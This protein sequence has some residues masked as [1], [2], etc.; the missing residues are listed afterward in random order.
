MFNWPLDNLPFRPTLNAQLF[1]E[2][3]SQWK[4]AFV[5]KYPRKHEEKKKETTYFFLATGHG[6]N[7]FAYEGELHY[8]SEISNS[9]YVFWRSKEVTEKLLKL[10]G[11]LRHTDQICY[12]RIVVEEDGNKCTLE[13]PTSLPQHDIKMYNKRVTCYVGFSWSGPKAYNVCLYDSSDSAVSDLPL[14]V[15]HQIH[16]PEPQ[17]PTSVPS[18]HNLQD[19]PILSRSNAFGNGACGYVVIR[20]S[21]HKFLSFEDHH[22]FSTYIRKLREEENKLRLRVAELRDSKAPAVEQKNVGVQL[23]EKRKQINELLRRRCQ[24]TDVFHYHDY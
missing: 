14:S 5:R 20:N 9:S 17:L 3:L 16:Q 21:T 4:N 13:I 19:F 6:M 7:A 12:V 1:P 2:I 11:V 18:L 22:T 15:Q 8:P 24:E 10:T 23:K